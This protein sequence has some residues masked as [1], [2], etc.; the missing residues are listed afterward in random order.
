M[1]VILHYR[2]PVMPHCTHGLYY[3][4]FTL[5]PQVLTDCIINLFRINNF[6]LFNRLRP[7]RP[8]YN[9]WSDCMYAVFNY[10]YPIMPH[11]THRLYYNHLTLCKK[12]KKTDFLLHFHR[13]WPHRPSYNW[14]S[15]SLYVIL[16]YRNPI[17]PHCTGRLYYNHL[18]LCKKK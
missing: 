6:A 17:M 11:C 3:N 15:D 4:H 8:S 1:Y 13:I 18:T 2:H 16:H 9:R 10:R 14:W 12:S 7:Y 5:F